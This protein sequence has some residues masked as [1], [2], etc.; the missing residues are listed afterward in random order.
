[1]SR[2]SRT[3]RRC[4]RRSGSAAAARPS[5]SRFPPGTPRELAR[6]SSRSARR[7]IAAR[8]RRGACSS[9]RTMPSKPRDGEPTSAPTSNE[10]VSEG[11]TRRR[12]HHPA[13]T[14]TTMRMK[15]KMKM[16]MNSAAARNARCPRWRRRGKPSSTTSHQSHRTK[17]TIRLPT[18]RGNRPSED[19]AAGWCGSITSRA[20][21]LF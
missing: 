3:S 15:M 17:T 6:W 11:T 7:G 8:T 21:S 9:R 19:E 18:R 12:R 5:A 1:M 14:T 10:S 4:T 20:V 2:T 16:K 13:T